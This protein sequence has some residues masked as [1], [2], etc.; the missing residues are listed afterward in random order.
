ME[1]LVVASKVKAFIKDKDCHTSSELFEALNKKVA[2]I[3]TNAC[4]RTKGNKRTT[5]KDVDL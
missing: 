2:E 1:M 3:L 5:V 4:E